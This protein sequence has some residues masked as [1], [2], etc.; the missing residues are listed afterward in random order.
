MFVNNTC[1]TLKNRATGVKKIICENVQY[2][3]MKKQYDTL[4]RHELE[5]KKGE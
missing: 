5:L 1:L 2:I 4:H 3:K